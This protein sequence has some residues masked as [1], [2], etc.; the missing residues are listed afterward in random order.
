[1]YNDFIN[2]KGMMTA[3]YKI[4]DLK[5]FKYEFLIIYQNTEVQS[6]LSYLKRWFKKRGLNDNKFENFQK[7]AKL[8]KQLK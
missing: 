4:E 1:M 2:D 5:I 6:Y 8:L 3:Y 7:T